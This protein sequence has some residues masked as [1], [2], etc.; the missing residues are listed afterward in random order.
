[1]V[2]ILNNVG[3]NVNQKDTDMLGSKL[4]NVIV[5]MIMDNMVLLISVPLNVMHQQLKVN[6]IRLLTVEVNLEIMYLIL[7]YVKNQKHLLNL[8][9]V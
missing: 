7:I 6:I 4:I 8:Q 3:R 5:V 1:M 2:I 9:H